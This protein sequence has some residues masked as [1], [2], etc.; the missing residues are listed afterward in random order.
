M[1]V[2]NDTTRTADAERKRRQANERKEVFVPDCASRLRRE[3]LEKCDEAWLRYY[4]GTANFHDLVPLIDPLVG[5]SLQQL[6]NSTHI[7]FVE[8]QDE[9]LFWY[10]FTGQQLA[11][12]EAIRTAIIY[13]GDQALAA[14]RGEGKTKLF[15]RMLLK[16]SLTGVIKF[17]VLFAATATAAMDSLESMR[18]E[19]E[20]N[21]RLCAD[22]PEVCIPVRALGDTPNR[23]HYQIVT[24]KRHDN[25]EAYVM[26]SSRFT[27]CGTDVV[28]PRVPGSPSAW[29]TIATRGLESA[30]LGLNKKNR[31][32]QVVGI[33]DPDTMDT[34][35]SEDSAKKLE[36]TIEKAIG[37]LGGQQ[38]GV[39]RVM[40]TTIRRKNCVSAWFT[41][42]KKKPS[43]KGRR[44]RFLEKPPERED[45]W[46]EYVNQWQLNK[47]AVDDKGD[48]T[49]PHSRGAN[50][51]YLANRDAMDVGAVVSNPNRYDKTPTP[52][53]TPLESSALQRYYNE[54]AR[55][56]IEAVE[57]ELQNNPPE[58][59]GPQTSG[60]TSAIVQSR[61]SGW[62]RRVV[63]STA[64][65]LTAAI[66]IGKYRCHWV[67]MAWLPGCVGLVIDNGVLEVVGVGK[68]DDRIAAMQAIKNALF[69]WREFINP[70]A[71]DSPYR[72]E[73]GEPVRI[74]LC[75]CDSGD[76]TDAVYA[77]VKEV[78]GKPF[79]ASKGMPNYR[80]HHSTDGKIVAADHW[81][82]SHQDNGVW[83]YLLDTD[84]WKHQLHD[85][86][87]TPT[88][89][90]DRTFRNGSLSLWEPHKD[91]KN[92]HHSY[93]KHIVAEE[94]RE[95]FI[96]GKGTKRVWH[97]VNANNH[98]LDASYMCIAAADMKGV[99][100]LPNALPTV[101]NQSPAPP[102]E[103]FT[104]P[105]GVPF[106]VTER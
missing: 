12:I 97:P 7:E 102:I 83:L 75:L 28:F 103:R 32:P 3:S 56:G 17:S 82:A 88:L 65:C 50:A 52:D 26:Q 85:R 25:G 21:E 74:D 69:H 1:A 59:A 45:L 15:E 16:Y 95:E 43:F 55:I 106:L 22:Y 14:S 4:C 98:W 81:H 42:P 67:V 72:D 6:V 76:M 71:G 91:S 101:R 18:S 70:P 40:L 53:A 31:R 29:A 20:G 9:P 57:T 47:Q 78:G 33:D 10:D 58:E 105:G 100:L 30:V 19:I 37:G 49:D 86:F 51:F 62:P 5:G 92:E 8:P 2:K 90:E 93:S 48:F 96:E 94:F 54:V 80:R 68:G 46:A 38:R 11:M 73:Q 13:G 34:M 60:I 99:K 79:M 84:F 87:L 39:A 77:F 66:D 27:W 24:G 23:A 44:F 104:A 35:R 64:I 41:D 36:E 63:P 89:N 61:L